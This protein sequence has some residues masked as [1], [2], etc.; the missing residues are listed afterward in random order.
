MWPRNADFLGVQLMDY[1]NAFSDNFLSFGGALAFVPLLLFVAGIIALAGKDWR[2]SIG[3]ILILLSACFG[4]VTYF[5]LPAGYPYPMDRHY[6]PSFVIFSLVTAYGAGVLIMNLHEIF[7]RYGKTIIPLILVLV[8]SSPAKQIVRNYPH[9]DASKKFFAHDYAVN[10]LD[11]VEKDAVIFIAGDNYWMPLYLQVAKGTRPDVVV[12]STSLLNA[13]WYVEQ[14]IERHPNLPLKLSKD[15]AANTA[16]VLWRD[17][18]VT[19]QVHGDP[20]SFRLPG[21]ARSPDEFDI[22][23]Q[24]TVAGQFILFYDWVVLRMIEENQWRRPIYFTSPPEWL[25]RYTRREGLLFR[26]VPQDP[27]ELNAE[28]LR[29]NLLERYTYRGFM[30]ASIPLDMRDRAYGQTLVSAF[31]ALAVH[32]TDLGDTSA[33]RQTMRGLRE[34][35]ILERLDF[36]AEFLEDLNDL[37]P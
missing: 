4:A 30:D 5:N 2:L 21:G 7:G 16:P 27:A 15:E 12:L 28:I 20:A 19:T 26:L 33:C 3:M 35:I 34:R 8:L 32:N 37:C 25:Q 36:Q 23:V 13:G 1:W 9:I 6:L 29:E 11:T 24:P 10:I 14:T 22:R 18:T 31:H 17:S